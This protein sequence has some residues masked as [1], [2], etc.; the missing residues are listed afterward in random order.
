MQAN[1]FKQIIKLI[2]NT[3][4]LAM[5]E[6]DEYIGQKELKSIIRRRDC[7]SVVAV[8]DKDVLGFAYGLIEPTNEKVGWLYHLAVKKSKRGAGIGKM[9]LAAFEKK[10]KQKKVKTLLLF[11]HEDLRLE[12]FYKKQGFK[13]GRIKLLNAIKEL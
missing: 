10:L 4:E 6:G 3:P 1:D 13:I 9:L 12:S 11:L 7:L 2:R 5:M 8:D